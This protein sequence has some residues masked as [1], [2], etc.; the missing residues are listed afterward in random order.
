MWNNS[1][2][3]KC[4]K[5]IKINN[6]IKFIKDRPGHDRVYNI[7]NHKIKKLGIKINPLNNN[8]LLKTIKFF[9]KNCSKN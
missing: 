7:S 6:S 3:R 2:T 4:N 9:L 5:N 1:D 8:N